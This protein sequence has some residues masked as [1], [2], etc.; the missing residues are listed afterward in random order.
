MIFIVTFGSQ[1]SYQAHPYYEDAH[2][3]GLVEIEAED[4]DDAREMAFSLFGT[5][6]SFIYSKE[7]FDKNES[8][9]YYPRGVLATVVVE[10]Q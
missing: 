6:W 4:E 2:P 3:D 9:R 10:K 8:R 1:Y 7:W 5:C